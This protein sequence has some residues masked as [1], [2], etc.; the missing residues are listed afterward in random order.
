[1][2]VGLATYAWVRVPRRY[3]AV[4]PAKW[5]QSCHVVGIA[6]LHLG[7]ATTGLHYD[8]EQLLKVLQ[9]LKEAGNT[10]VSLF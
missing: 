7:R 1:M 9:R 6:A 3:P 2:D 4:R 10:V 5:L 8:I